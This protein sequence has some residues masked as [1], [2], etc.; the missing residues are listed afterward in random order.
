MTL[1]VTLSLTY[2]AMTTKTD[3]TMMGATMF[4][5]SMVLLLFGLLTMIFAN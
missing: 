4:I 3:V 2:Y 5:L 1:G